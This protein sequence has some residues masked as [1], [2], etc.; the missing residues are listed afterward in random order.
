M[1]TVEE[2][3]KLA[4][5]AKELQEKEK[6]TYG[7]IGAKLGI[8]DSYT[9]KL[10]RNLNDGKYDKAVKEKPGLGEIADDSSIVSAVTEEFKL[11]GALEE[12]ENVTG[13]VIGKSNDSGWFETIGVEIEIPSG[14]KGDK[15]ELVIQSEILK[16]LRF[17]EI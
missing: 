17:E 14:L 16:Q 1:R 8:S 5:A 7:Q 2:R 4:Q 15:R 3:K 10:I 9:S 12:T 11:Q 13:Y 6:L